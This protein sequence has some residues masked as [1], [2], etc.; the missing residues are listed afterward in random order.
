M[1]KSL[2]EWLNFIEAV[3]PRDIQ[4]GLDRVRVVAD[5]LGLIPPAARTVIVAGTNG[6]G[7]TAV[8]TEFLLRA[9]GLTVGTTLSPHVH[10]FNERIRLDG[11]LCSHG[12]NRKRFGEETTTAI[13]AAE[14]RAR[15]SSPSAPSG[16]EL[17]RSS[18]SR[19]TQLR[20]RRPS[21]VVFMS[22]ER[23]ATAAGMTR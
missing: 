11:E 18:R 7:S 16:R 13:S 22:R 10:V 12:S 15:T 2:E 19:V 17:G 20:N 23:A 1:H 5:T 8:F 4:L 9:G 3:H 21:R 14:V 6:K